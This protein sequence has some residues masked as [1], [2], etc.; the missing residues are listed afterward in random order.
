APRARHLPRR[1]QRQMTLSP[2]DMRE[3]IGANRLSRPT[4]IYT[5]S[6]PRDWLPLESRP[7]APVP[8]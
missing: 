6:A 5:G 8:A 1:R 3:Q 7:M 4:E 2:T